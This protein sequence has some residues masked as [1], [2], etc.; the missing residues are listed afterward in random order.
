MTSTLHADQIASLRAN[1]QMFN[2]RQYGA[3]DL[4]DV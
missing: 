2:F 4:K 1:T 3:N